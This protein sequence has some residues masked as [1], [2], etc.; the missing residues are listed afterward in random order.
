[1][2]F[3]SFY[4][5]SLN[6]ASSTACYFHSHHFPSFALFYF[7]LAFQT[8][9]Q[10]IKLAF[11]LKSLQL[12]SQPDFAVLVRKTFGKSLTLNFEADVAICI[13][14]MCWSEIQ[15]VVFMYLLMQIRALGGI[16]AFL[17]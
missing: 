12:S 4:H 5:L 7:F 15:P 3:Y 11:H 16:F 9:L 8:A 2:V 10:I 13:E 14:G 17:P 1:M 6:V